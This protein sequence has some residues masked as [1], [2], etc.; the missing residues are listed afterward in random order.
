[1]IHEIE[2]PVNSEHEKNSEADDDVEMTWIEVTQN[3]I[4]QL[5]LSLVTPPK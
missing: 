3:G 4:T 2:D 5:S 1:M